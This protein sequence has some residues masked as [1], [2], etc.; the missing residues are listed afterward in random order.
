MLC[1]PYKYVSLLILLSA[2]ACDWSH[3][4]T[5]FQCVGCSHSFSVS[6]H[7]RLYVAV[8]SK[9]KI[10]LSSWIRKEKVDTDVPMKNLKNK[11]LKKIK[12]SATRRLGGGGEGVKEKSI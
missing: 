10:S 7:K 4:K 5:I 9:P 6:P 3:Q 11:R 2:L 8:G 12:A 1:I